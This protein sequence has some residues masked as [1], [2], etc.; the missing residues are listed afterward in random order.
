MLST[1]PRRRQRASWQF[2]GARHD[3][4]HG[5]ANLVVQRTLEAAAGALPA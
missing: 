1:G 2:L 4:G 3:L 5:C